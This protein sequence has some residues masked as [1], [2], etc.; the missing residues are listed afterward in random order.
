MDKHGKFITET[1]ANARVEEMKRVRQELIY[2]LEQDKQHAHEVEHQMEEA[3][4][5]DVKEGHVHDDAPKK[6]KS[7]PQ[8]AASSPVVSATSSAQ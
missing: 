2:R 8:V 1:E 3:H 6:N 5:Q 7:E 4:E